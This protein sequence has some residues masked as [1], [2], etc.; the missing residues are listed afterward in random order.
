MTTALV[1]HVACLEHAPLPGH[2]E[3]PARLQAVLDAL[4]GDDF[5][6]LRRERAPRARIGALTRVHQR[7]YIKSV[8]QSIPSHGFAVIDSDTIVSPGSVEAA[9]RAAGAV[10]RGVDLVMKGEVE[11]AFCAVRPPGH[12]AGPA[13]AMGFCL[14]N[15][16]A[17]GAAHARAAHGVRRIGILDFDV[18]HGNGTEAIFASD[19]DVFY[20]STHQSPLYPGTGKVEVSDHVCNRPLD[21]GATGAAFRPA[22]AE[23]IAALEQFA[24]ELV[25]ISAGFDAHRDDPM[26]QLRFDESDFS[27]ATEM[28]CG[29]AKKTAAGRVVSSLEGGYDLG[30]LGRAARAH[31][32]ALMAA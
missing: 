29:L 18:H 31:V 10:V 6:S 24:P 2:P 27:W 22:F 17:V 25:L 14:F 13:R 1:S 11:N 20:G 19:P 3:Q 32:L 28:A 15:N 5:R 8:L 26:A 23:I 30:A 4:S 12:H 16:I 21:P 9:L 7:T